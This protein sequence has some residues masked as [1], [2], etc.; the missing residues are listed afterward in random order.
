MVVEPADDLL[1]L[2]QKLIAAVAPFTVK[3]GTA[4]AYATTPE[5]PDINAPTLDYVAGFVPNATGKHFNPHVTVGIATQDYLKE[6][7][8][9][10]FS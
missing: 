2:Q 4:A 10:P 6:M 5:D 9:E 3:T 8:A 1:R 7:L